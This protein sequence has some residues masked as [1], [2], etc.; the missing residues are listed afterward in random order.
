MKVLVSGAG[1]AGTCLAYWLA[2]HGFTPTLVE[3]APQLRRGGYVIDFWGA[4]YDVAERMDLVDRLVARG[5]RVREV[6]EVDRNG[7]RVGGFPVRALDRATGGRYTSL[8][9]GDLAAAL[10]ETLEGR[11]E[12]IFGDSIAAIEDRDGRA[13][14]RFER[15]GSRVFDLVV[16]ADGLHSRVR[17]LVFGEEALFERFLGMKVAAFEIDGYRPRDELAY[18]IH[19]EL[20]QQVGRFSLRGDRTMFLFI[21]AD[22]R[23]ELPSELEE[24]KALLRQKFATSGWEC[25]GILG[26]LDRC[27]EL[28][29]DRVSQIRMDAWARGR[30]ALVGDSAACVSF[31]AGQGSALAMVGAYLLAGEL[32]R[33]EGDHDA[34]FARY[35]ERL[36]PL[37]RGKQD[38][39]IRLSSYF[40]P[41]SRFAMF[42]GR[43]VM[44]LMG[45]PLV[46]ELALARALKDRI[47]LPDY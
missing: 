28:Y 42:V 46:A 24:Q 8:A 27:Q 9:R 11:V 5:Y 18:L 12:T 35:Q 16:G 1:V 43:Q 47:R 37:V 22:E 23:A 40:A 31:L 19:R 10:Y 30:V 2:R 4:G 33:A 7:L 38:A 15:S 21:F 44:R 36:R 41:P 25:P 14:V 39:A 6:R 34:A 20:G 13:M 45:V 32:R 29:I 3:R 26:A 17:R